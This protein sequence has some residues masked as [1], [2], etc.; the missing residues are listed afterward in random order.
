M[1]CALPSERR[2]LSRSDRYF[3]FSESGSK[4]ISPTSS[5]ISGSRIMVRLIHRVAVGDCTKP[6]MEH[7]PA[8][9]WTTLTDDGV[10]EA[11]MLQGRPLGIA[12]PE[13][14]ACP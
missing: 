1:Y 3:V 7:N 2:R 12:A 13:V 6:A 14:S 11:N 4:S 9:A 10:L 5:A 8:R